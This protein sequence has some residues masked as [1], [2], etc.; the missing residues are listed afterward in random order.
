MSYLKPLSV[1]IAVLI[2]FLFPFVLVAEQME[3]EFRMRVE[4]RENLRI[5]IS[6]TMGEVTIIGHDRDELVIEPADRNR[7]MRSERAE[8]LRSLFNNE[9]D[10]TNLGLSVTWEQDGVRI[11]SASRRPGNFTMYVPDRVQLVYQES[12][13]GVGALNVLNHSGKIVVQT[14]ASPV[15]L[16]DVTGPLMVSAGASNVQVLFSEVSQQNASHISTVSGYVDI[17][18]PQSTAATWGLRTEAGDIFT[19][20]DLESQVDQTTSGR[21]G[22]GLNVTGTTGGGGVTINVTS[23]AGNVYLRKRE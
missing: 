14:V 3:E 1:L 6:L 23:L 20:L 13:P 7:P 10:N 17:T 8:G 5:Q 19:N 12:S 16:M 4:N 18:L 9:E 11:V 22:R 15:S 2:P 21:M